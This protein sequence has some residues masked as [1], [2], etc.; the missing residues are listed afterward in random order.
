MD[1]EGAA[2]PVDPKED[3]PT[4]EEVINYEETRRS[5][6][7]E[8]IN[9]VKAPPGRKR[10][11][12]DELKALSVRNYLDE[13]VVPQLLVAMSE[14]ARRRPERPLEWLSKYLEREQAKE[15]GEVDHRGDSAESPHHLNHGGA[16]KENSGGQDA[17]L[18]D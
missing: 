7:E 8:L 18:A 12:L 5:V 14:L 16:S 6:Q 9:T 11:T 2:A 4:Q 3:A 13:T 17:V 10:K 1:V 15:T